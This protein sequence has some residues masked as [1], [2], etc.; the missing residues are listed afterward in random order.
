MDVIYE[1]YNRIMNKHLE[2]LCVSCA[3]KKYNS[4]ENN[5]NWNPNLSDE[6]RMDRRVNG[7]YGLFI[8]KV[9]DRDGYICRCCG[10]SNKNTLIVHHLDGYNWCRER[11]YDETNAITL[12]DTCHSNFHV[13]YGFGNNTKQQFLDWMNV[14]ELELQ[15][16]NNNIT[17][18]RKIYCY[19]DDKVYDSVI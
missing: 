17:P 9:L 7:D 10:S 6:D 1:N 4:G 18:S 13:S 19:E 3:N 8:K 16:N 15:A 2:Y 12:C 14:T 5:W 11:R